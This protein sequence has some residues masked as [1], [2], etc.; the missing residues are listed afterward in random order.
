[1]RSRRT[2]TLV[3]AFAVSAV[4]AAPVAAVADPLPAPAADGAFVYVG[5]GDTRWSEQAVSCDTGEQQDP[6]QGS[7]GM[8]TGLSPGSHVISISHSFPKVETYATGLYDGVDLSDLTRLMY[9]SYTQPST[10]DPFPPLGFRL[11]VDSDDDG[12]PDAHLYF[13]PA[14]NADQHAP[15]RNRWQEWDVLGGRVTLSGD[16]P[17][18]DATTFA[19][20]ATAHP[21]A[22]MVPWDGEAGSLAL[23]GGCWRGP[24]QETTNYGYYVDGVLIG[25][26]GVTTAYRFADEWPSR[27]EQDFVRADDHTLYRYKRVAYDDQTGE[28]LEP[29]SS[30]DWVESPMPLSEVPP[31]GVGVLSIPLPADAVSR[32]EQWWTTTFDTTGLGLIKHFTYQTWSSSEDGSSKPPPYLRLD[33]DVDLDDA[34]DDSIYFFPG[35][36]LGQGAPANERWQKWDAGIGLW[37][38]SPDPGAGSLFTLR[39]YALEHPHATIAQTTP[40]FGNP[41]GFHLLAGGSQSGQSGGTYRVDDVVLAG[42]PDGGVDFEPPIT[43]PEITVHPGRVIEGNDGSTTLPVRIRLSAREPVPVTV[44]VET[45]G[46][47]AKPY[48]DFVPFEDNRFTIDTADRFATFDVQV[49]GDREWEPNEYFRVRIKPVTIG[50]VIEPVGQAWIRNDDTLVKLDAVPRADQRVDV[51]V[52]TRAARPG[53]VVDILRGTTILYSGVLDDA[54]KLQRRLDQRF[55][56]G[57][58]V[59]LHARVAT[60]NVLYRSDPIVTR[61]PG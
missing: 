36:N 7:A 14:Y 16:A 40:E 9:S 35:E 38:T 25:L 26:D 6:W 45:L 20:Y 48:V 46:G 10:S 29:Q 53:A 2:R 3:A 56:P 13:D 52:A 49:V 30:F 60:S 61:I 41:G 47:T 22:R 27:P 31:K 37:S 58:T 44:D 34:A 21:D 51:S 23:I 32:V 8:S 42:Y 57:S 1:M 28:P 12:A 11:S 33:V 39:Q 50:Y 55:R 4:S 17:A 15:L 18:E 54:G 43:D 19:D 24:L 59:R 5:H